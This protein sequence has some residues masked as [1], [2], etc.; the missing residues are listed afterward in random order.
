VAV[1]NTFATTKKAR[2]TKFRA[3]STFTGESEKYPYLK[4]EIG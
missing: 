1:D 3:R 4:E 2:I